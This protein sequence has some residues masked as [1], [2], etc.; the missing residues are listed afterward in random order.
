MPVARVIEL[1]GTS[2]KSFDDALNQAIKRTS[3]TVRGI[4]GV[5][6]IGQKALVKNGKITEYRVH[7]KL[8]F[9]VE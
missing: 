2:N 9:S 5:D 8:S 3:K 6:V 1:V 7:V 4:R